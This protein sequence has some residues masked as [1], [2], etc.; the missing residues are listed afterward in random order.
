MLI[1][2]IW[3]DFTAAGAGN[4]QRNKKSLRP[5]GERKRTRKEHV[6]Q[7]RGKKW[8]NSEIIT[9]D[10]E[11]SAQKITL[12]ARVSERRKKSVERKAALLRILREFFFLQNSIF[13]FSHKVADKLVY[14]FHWLTLTP[15]LYKWCQLMK[16][17][18]SSPYDTL[19][20]GGRFVRER[21]SDD[22]M[23]A[24]NIKAF[25]SRMK[26]SACNISHE[27]ES[28]L[29]CELFCVLFLRIFSLCNWWDN[30]SLRA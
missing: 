13:H 24:I 8:S 29:C 7:S 14:K 10:I 1:S 30:K 3:L 21:E 25:L 22:V 9:H 26:H 2:A 27:R 19:K 20:E 17:F 16:Y 15:S 11:K 12:Q 23:K 5:N 28:N 6:H 4:Y 18:F